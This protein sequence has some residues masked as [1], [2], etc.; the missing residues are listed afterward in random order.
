M[1]K[2][3]K[4]L[5][6]PL[7][8]VAALMVP[9]TAFATVNGVTDIN[10]DSPAA[11]WESD[12]YCGGWI[13]TGDLNPPPPDTTIGDWLY[14]NM[15]GTH[16]YSNFNFRI[17]GY[18]QSGTYLGY[19]QSSQRSGTAYGSNI[20]IPPAYDLIYMYVNNSQGNADNYKM[21]LIWCVT[22]TSC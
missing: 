13:E 20:A 6:L 5:L 15:R 10:C 16:S 14:G 19:V 18:T 21:K 9:T 8:A 1:K 7:A 17:Y 3:L 4:R 11:G 22:G 12:H 2:F